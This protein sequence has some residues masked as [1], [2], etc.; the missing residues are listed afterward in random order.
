MSEEKTKPVESGCRCGRLAAI[1]AQLE[2]AKK[3]AE[4]EPTIVTPSEVSP[5]AVDASATPIG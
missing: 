4:G 2:E 5:P 1:R 3:K